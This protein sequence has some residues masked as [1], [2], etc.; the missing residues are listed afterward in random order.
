MTT[1][2]PNQS[3]ADALAAI[4]AGGVARYVE[5]LPDY[6]RPTVR[7]FFSEPVTDAEYQV[8]FN[9]SR[10]D[11]KRQREL[12]LSCPLADCVG[13]ED[14]SCPIR[15]EARRLWRNRR[16]PWHPPPSTLDSSAKD[17]TRA[18]TASRAKNVRRDSGR[19][20]NP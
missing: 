15:I 18:D 14:A 9:V 20:L 11:E 6:A 16:E 2:T 3:P 4:I 1:T 19:R 17:T 8:E 12:C 13:V 5:S 7:Q 10:V